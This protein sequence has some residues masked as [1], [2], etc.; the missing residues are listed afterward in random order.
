MGVNEGVK[1]KK[2]LAT[3]WDPVIML[4]RPDMRVVSA[5]YRLIAASAIP[6]ALL[7]LDR[8]FVPTTSP[9]HGMCY[10][11]E[12]AKAQARVPDEVS[13]SGRRHRVRDTEPS[14]RRPAFASSDITHLCTPTSTLER[15]Y[16]EQ[17]RLRAT[18]QPAYAPLRPASSGPLRSHTDE[19]SSS[20]AWRPSGASTLSQTSR[21]TTT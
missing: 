18:W 10:D 7:I 2:G 17:P 12:D 21:T 4:D 19:L 3:D 20:E 8:C 14:P 15:V 1:V 6:C 9:C 16:R 5:L 11:I 13:E